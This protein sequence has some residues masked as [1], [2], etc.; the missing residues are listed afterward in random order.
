[1]K[2][3]SRVKACG[4]AV[5]SVAGVC[6]FCAFPGASLVSIA[7]LALVFIA[8]G[9]LYERT[10]IASRTGWYTLFSAMV[11]LSLGFAANVWYFTVCSGGTPADPVLN[12]ND[13]YVAWRHIIEVRTGEPFVG[14]LFDT[15]AS[16]QGYGVLMGWLSAVLGLDI[17]TLLVVNVF[18]VLMTI[19]LSG[20]IAVELI[21]TDADDQSRRRIGGLAMLMTAAICYFLASGVILIKDALSCMT[22]AL[23]VYGVLRMRC[24][25]FE[26]SIRF[27][28]VTSA[29]VAAALLLA[30]QIRPNFLPMMI[31]GFII[32]GSYKRRSSL[33]ACMAGS[34]LAAGLYYISE[35]MLDTAPSFTALAT[36][37]EDIIDE[38]SARLDGYTSVVGGYIGKPFY[39]K[40]LQLPVSAAVQFLT[41]LPWGFTK[42][43]VFGPSQI[44]SHVSY[45]WYAV[46][47][48]AIYYML[49]CLRRSPDM[50]ARTCCYGVLLTLIT[51]YATGGTISRYCLPWLPLLVPAAVWVWM[52]CRGEKSFRIYAAVYVVL[53]AVVLFGVWYLDMSSASGGAS[54]K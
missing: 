39:A 49:F 14:D 11:L 25:A 4:I 10:G 3:S 53:M 32:L 24:Q 46:G 19:V 47:G 26:D 36:H 5:V 8:T 44:W 12:N 13:A 18:A 30:F 50:L 42:H 6:F 45:P 9:A 37:S 23:F 27:R 20:M 22:M 34:V 31:L 7:F 41:P 33:Y 15:G 35:A 1:M 52:N 16:R 28:T 54:V 29:V 43:I 17:G 21:G 51:A 48:M 38:N 40:L 2:T